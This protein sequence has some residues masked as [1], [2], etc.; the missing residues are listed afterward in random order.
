LAGGNVWDSLADLMKTIPPGEV[1][2]NAEKEVREIVQHL[3]ITSLSLCKVGE[4]ANW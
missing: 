3:S 2:I 1:K 4:M